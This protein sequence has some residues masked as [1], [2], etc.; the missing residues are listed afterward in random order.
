MQPGV[1][2][3]IP[4]AMLGVALVAKLPA[5][6]RGW[7]SPMVR[8]VNFVI[9]LPCA[10][11][12]LSAPP[13]VT[14]VNRVTGI[15][16]LSALLVHCV[17]TAYSCACL[18]LTEHWR[19]DSRADLR[20][21][22]R[23]R[24]WILGCCL[25]IAAIVVLFLVGEAPVERPRD[26]D[27]YYATTPFIG[28]MLVLYLLAYVVAAVATAAMCWNWTLDI[29][30]NKG[31]GQ[32]TT[33]DGSLRVGLLVLVIASVA[34]IIFGVFKL[35]AIAARWAG[36]DWDVLN[37]SLAPFMSVSGMMIGFGF[38]VPVFGPRLIERVWQPFRLI[39]ALGPLWRLVRH[40]DTASRNTMLLTTPWYSGPEQVL[41]YRMT[42]IHDWM[43]EL[44]AY[45]TDE[46]RGLAHH[47]AKE[48]GS[49][50]REAVAVGLAAM[51]KAAAH[52]RARD[53][54]ADEEQSVLAAVA[55]RSAE[56]EYRGLLVAISR[57]LP[58]APERADLL[59]C[60]LTAAAEREG[61][62]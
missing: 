31:R 58:T 61:T 29:S 44:C 46:V 28:E 55:L 45:C 35:T 48:S 24:G 56:S 39:L 19:G 62:V 17:L 47:R 22:Q 43:L 42:N 3:Y 41:V 38:L 7:R 12:V 25:V 8:T 26:F 21:K 5:L 54:P 11:F 57:A 36:R 14:L 16:N 49:T 4:A 10:G 34:N 1:N 20:T 60:P 33:V 32:K 40:P 15:S 23:V 30:R 52:D 51:F 37:D 18:V 53:S 6:L 59:E 13:T 50:E 2:Y 9:F 27:T